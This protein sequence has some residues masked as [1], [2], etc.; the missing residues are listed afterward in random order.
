MKHARSA[1]L[2]AAALL[3]GCV[4]PYSRMEPGDLRWYA[5]DRYQFASEMPAATK[6]EGFDKVHAYW[7]TLEALKQV[8]KDARLTLDGESMTRDEARRRVKDRIAETEKT[9]SIGGGDYCGRAC[10]WTAM[11]PLKVAVTPIE[12]LLIGLESPCADLK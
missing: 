5:E 12:A 9:A 1:I 4:S 11:I 6:D 7:E 10:V 8:D 2:I 3:A